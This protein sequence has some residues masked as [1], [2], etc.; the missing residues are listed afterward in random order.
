MV[1][2]P[3]QSEE[4]AP[5]PEGECAAESEVPGEPPP[6]LEEKEEVKLSQ[7]SMEMA[8]RILTELGFKERLVGSQITEMAGEQE[9]YIYS[10]KEATDLLHCD[11]TGLKG[12]GSIGYIEPNKL[13]EWI[14]SIFGDKELAQVIEEK[15]KEG[16]SYKDRAEAI[17]PLM[18]QRL[19]QCKEIA[20]EETGA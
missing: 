11:V 2:L 3:E 20:G 16:S 9:E 8:T 12:S 10:F 17:R 4:L 19:K 13:A 14:R 1:E 6:E 7:P 15:I 5:Q 18:E